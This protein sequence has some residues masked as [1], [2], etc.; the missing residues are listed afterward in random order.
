MIWKQDRL[1]ADIEQKTQLKQRVE[2]QLEQDMQRFKDMGKEA[3]AIIAKARHANSKL[4]V[5][6]GAAGPVLRAHQLVLQD[7]NGQEGICR[8]PWVGQLSR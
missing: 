3:A 8:W 1:N 4:Q 5:G 2:Q 6:H 7:K